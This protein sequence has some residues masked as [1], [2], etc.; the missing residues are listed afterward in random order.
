MNKLSYQT[1]EELKYDGYLLLTEAPAWADTKLKASDT[2]REIQQKWADTHSPADAL[3]AV[4]AAYHTDR[5]AEK[6]LPADAVSKL[7]DT[8]RQ[9]R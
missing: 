9:L 5:Y 2:V 7:T 3:D 6:D 1:L 4:T 8:L